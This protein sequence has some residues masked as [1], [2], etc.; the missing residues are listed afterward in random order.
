M[1][2][3]SSVANAAGWLFIS[4]LISFDWMPDSA[5]FALSVKWFHVHMYI[6]KFCS[7]MWPFGVTLIP[8]GKIWGQYRTM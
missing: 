6:L 1:S 7:E 8:I 2:E 4:Y 3:P 5:N